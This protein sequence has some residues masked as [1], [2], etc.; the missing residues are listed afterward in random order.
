MKPLL[1]RAFLT[2]NRLAEINAGNPRFPAKKTL[3]GL[4]H[5]TQVNLEVSVPNKMYLARRVTHKVSLEV[6]TACSSMF[7]P[8][9]K[10]RPKG[11]LLPVLVF[12]H[13]G[14]LLY[15][16]GNWKGLHPTPEMVVDMNCCRG[17]LQLQAECVWFPCVTI[18][19]RCFIHKYVRELW[20]Y[21]SDIG[22]K[23]GQN[24]H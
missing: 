23:V 21:G 11:K 3:V 4:G 22:I 13:G 15:L 5:L 12:I 20:I 8:P 1:S 10:E 14:F 6:K 2:Q 7:G 18:T 9:P 24:K 16:S 17:L 19:G